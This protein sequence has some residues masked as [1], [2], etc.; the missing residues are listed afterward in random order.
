MQRTDRVEGN[1]GW[2]LQQNDEFYRFYTKQWRRFTKE[3]MI[4][5][6]KGRSIAQK[7]SRKFHD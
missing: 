1:A 5:Q 2:F 7:G 3:M 4:L 6:Q